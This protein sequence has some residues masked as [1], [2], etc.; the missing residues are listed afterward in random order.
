MRSTMSISYL[1]L[2]ACEPIGA[3]AR[4]E[5][6]R[7]AARGWR[8]GRMRRLHGSLSGCRGLQAVY[9]QDV[10]GEGATATGGVDLGPVAPRAQGEAPLPKARIEIGTGVCRDRE[11]RY[12]YISEVT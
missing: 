9:H 6:D 3:L 7:A 2:R 12:L 4:A 10:V 1:I 5:G 8:G 11:C